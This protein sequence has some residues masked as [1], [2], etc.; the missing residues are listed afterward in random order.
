MVSSKVRIESLLLTI[1]LE[2][3]SHSHLFHHS[4]E[5][6]K[7]LLLI[8][9]PV[10]KHLKKNKQINAK[11][12]LIISNLNYKIGGEEMGVTCV[13]RRLVTFKRVPCAVLSMGT[14]WAQCLWSL[15]RLWGNLT[16]PA[17]LIMSFLSAF[18]FKGC[19]F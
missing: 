12:Y 8:L 19:G 3:F 10:F 5:T 18:N 11:F 15:I 16:L 6:K 2:C 1:I 14:C 7:Y 17:C 13:L 4:E 9:V